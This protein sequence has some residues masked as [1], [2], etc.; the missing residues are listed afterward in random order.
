VLKASHGR[1]RPTNGGIIGQGHMS[2]SD[3][4]NTE[5]IINHK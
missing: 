3:W 4:H 5:K 2:A 1:P